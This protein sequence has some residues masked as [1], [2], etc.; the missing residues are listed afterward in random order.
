[1]TPLDLNITPEMDKNEIASPRYFGGKFKSF[2]Q[3]LIENEFTDLNIKNLIITHNGD[4]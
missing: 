4:E 3:K 1:M 2:T